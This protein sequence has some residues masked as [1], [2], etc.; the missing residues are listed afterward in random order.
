MDTRRAAKLAK[1]LNVD[2][3]YG[4]LDTLGAHVQELSAGGS[5]A[6]AGTLLD[7]PPY[8]TLFR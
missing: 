7:M 2:D 3:V 4:R 6:D 1:N 8:C 5:H